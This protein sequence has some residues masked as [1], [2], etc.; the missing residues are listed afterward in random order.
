[1]KIVRAEEG[2]KHIG[3]TF[4]GRAELIRKLSAQEEGGIALALVTFIDGALTHWHDHPGEQVLL[5]L[6]G[7]GRVGNDEEEHE[8]K[9]GDIVYTGPGERHW[10][11]AAAGSSMTHLSITTVGPPNWYGPVE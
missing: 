9:A 2:E 1:M 8:L 10:H 3:T 7:R 4:S 5:V 11:G 6:E